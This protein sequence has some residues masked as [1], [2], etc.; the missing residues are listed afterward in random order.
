MNDA[1][2]QLMDEEVGEDE[3]RD[4]D[5]SLTLFASWALEQVDI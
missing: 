3:P 1:L 5:I 4:L 2:N